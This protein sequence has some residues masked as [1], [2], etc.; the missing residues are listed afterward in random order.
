MQL[1]SQFPRV[2]LAHRPTPLERMP[3][4]SRE[5]ERDHLFVKRDDCTGLAM[6]GNKVRQLEFYFG[7][8]IAENATVVLITGAVQSNYV[9]CA[10]AAAAKTGLRCLIQLEDRV[11]G[12]GSE[13]HESGNV[14]LD[15]MLGAEIRMYP[16]GEDEAG[17]D[18]SLDDLADSLRGEGQRPYVVHLGDKHPPLGALAY[19]ETAEEILT[20]M[21]AHGVDLG[22]VIVASGSAH[23][24][25]GLLVGFRVQERP[26][27]AVHGVCVRRDASAQAERVL[28]FARATEELI[29]CGRRVHEQDVLV[30]DKY[31]GP[32][33]GRL[34]PETEDAM[35][36]AARLEGL[37]LDP[38][39]TAKAFAHFLGLIRENALG[40]QSAAIFLHTGG[41]PALFAYRGLTTEP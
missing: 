28:K 25:A 34:N 29:G 17:A 38:V 11:K 1:L 24:H 5:L 9:R 10:A 39:Y 20:Q 37:L 36:T 21:S 31:L 12:M 15:H 16:E 22:S 13:Y 8:A 23:T 18:R 33:Y 30:T 35:L 4:L 19:V 3:N 2:S 26:D 7:Q 41:T 27:V 32:G 14:L 6:G 40:N